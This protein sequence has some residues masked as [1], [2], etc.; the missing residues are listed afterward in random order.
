MLNIA[1]LLNRKPNQLSGGQQQRV[2]I[3]KALIRNP[4]LF[5]MDEPLSSLD[6]ELKILLRTEIKELHSKL[7][8][9]FVYVTHDQSEAMSL[10]TK[11]VV[12]KD[13]I[14]QQTGTPYEA[15]IR[16]TNKFVASFIGQHKINF[17]DLDVVGSKIYFGKSIIE[18][19]KIFNVKTISIGIRPED[20][21]LDSNGSIAL[22]ITN[23]EILGNEMLVTGKF[24]ERFAASVIL[25]TDI[26]IK[27]GDIVTLSIQQEKIHLCASIWIC[28]Y[29]ISHYFVL[30]ISNYYY[31][32][33]DAR[34]TMKKR[35]NIFETIILIVSCLFS[36]I[37]F[38]IIFICSFNDSVSI[39]KGDIITGISL[40]NFIDNFITLFS[41]ED[42]IVAL[43]N[44][45]LVSVITVV[46]SVLI[47]SI[48]GYSYSVYNYRLLKCM[49]YTTIIALMVPSSALLIPT[50]IM[51]S[52][53]KLLDRLISVCLVSLTTP[54][55]VFLFKQSTDM[56]PKQLLQTA[57]LDGL[58]EPKIFLK[59]YFPNMIPTFVTSGVLVFFEVWNGLLFPLIILQSQKNIML[60]IFIN[61]YGTSYTT[62]YGS[63]M[64][65][66]LIT[67]LP[68]IL[69]FIF[70]RKHFFQGLNDAL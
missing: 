16:P 34:Q 70:T 52:E 3:G 53:F 13:G 35:L 42:F 54:L 55:I 45:I 58:S 9:T 4:S 41:K 28:Y 14:I 31:T 60:P 65:L 12:I 1:E 59:V 39:R 6:A 50:F 49:F 67:M 48:A 11:L 33:F 38:F 8:S 17:F 19:S 26:N 18:I 21:V 43:M 2:A 62:N 7:K 24:G 64:L 27:N 44:T 32:I 57:R 22:S 36:L 61:S 66:L 25:P 37:P 69:L 5:L 20:F 29:N 51:F 30:F 40:R 56:F 46:I 63:F 47:S 10:S 23:I 15:F 68:T